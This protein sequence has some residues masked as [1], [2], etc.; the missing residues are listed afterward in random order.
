MEN[1]RS[2]REQINENTIY[3][4]NYMKNERN[5]N[6]NIKKGRSNDQVMVNK[7]KQQNGKWIKM[8]KK[9]FIKRDKEENSEGNRTIHRKVEDEETRRK[10]YKFK[11]KKELQKEGKKPE[12]KSK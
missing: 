6:E 12:E 10:G 3:K 4:G 9:H 7:T 1:R 5:D 11:D 8:R 2:L